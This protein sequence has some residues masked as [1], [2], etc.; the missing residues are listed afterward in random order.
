MSKSAESTVLPED[1]P[2]AERAAERAASAAAA[3]CA[4]LAR[5]VAAAAA[6]TPSPAG[7]ATRDA[8]RAAARAAADTP[9]TP[10]TCSAGDDAAARAAAALA[11]ATTCSAGDFA[12]AGGPGMGVSPKGVLPLVSRSNACDAWSRVGWAWRGRDGGL[13]L[14]KG[15]DAEAGGWGWGGRRDRDWG[16][17]QRSVRRRAGRSLTAVSSWNS[18]AAAVD[19]LRSGWHSLARSR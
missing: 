15:R 10:L 18:S 7:D 2:A 5:A 9:L 3:L 6:D 8:A 4:A 17:G 12:L 1:L 11:L 13:R 19:G 14:S 16:R